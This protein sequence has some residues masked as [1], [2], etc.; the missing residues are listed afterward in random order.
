MS[1]PDTPG[2]QS[3]EEI[4]VS[5][6]QSLSQGK[7]DAAGSAANGHASATDRPAVGGPAPDKP[8]GA[9]DRLGL[10]AR[11]AGAL[12]GAHGDGGLTDDSL[13]DLLVDAAKAAAEAPSAADGAKTPAEAKDP[14]WFLTRPQGADEP[15][16]AGSGNGAASSAKAPEPASPAV[17]ALK[18]SRPET[19]RPSLPPLFGADAAR[20]AKLRASD[21]V[22][23]GDAPDVRPKAQE[24]APPAAKAAEAAPEKSAP[25][26]QPAVDTVAPVAAAAPTPAPSAEAKSGYERSETPAPPGD[27]AAVT[28]APA[29]GK[30]SKALEQ[31]IAQLLEPVLRSWLEQNLPA[32]IEKVIREEVARAMAAERG[33]VGKV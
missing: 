24:A 29:D 30:P 13:A 3:L 2:S 6:R 31:M 26:A 9:A 15:N 20:A 33:G 10:S 1:K 4:L 27:A 21:A 18:L 16:A 5:I 8:N 7:P 22:K 25:A 17:E 19:L 23:P 32:M 14:L 28:P 11:L 12:N